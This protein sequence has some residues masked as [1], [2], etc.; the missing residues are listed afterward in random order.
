MRQK[1]QYKAELTLLP[2]L[3]VKPLITVIR[4]IV[5]NSLSTFTTTSL[6]LSYLRKTYVDK[7]PLANIKL[8]CQRWPEKV[9]LLGGMAPNILPW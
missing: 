8:D 4:A 7:A 6:R 3:H 9:L 2:H 5:W 1:G